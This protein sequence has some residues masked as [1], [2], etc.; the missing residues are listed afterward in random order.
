MAWSDHKFSD[1]YSAARDK[2]KNGAVADGFKDQKA[3]LLRALSDS[4]FEASA[5]TALEALR[6][7]VRNPVTGEPPGTQQ[8]SR[9]LRA[10]GHSGAS[11]GDIDQDTR[12]R[13]GALK[14]VSH[15]YMLKQRGAQK[16]WI[17]NLPTDFSD[18]PHYAASA[19]SADAVRP[20]LRSTNEKFSA[21][22]L[23]NLSD[24]MQ[25]G[26]RWC[27]KTLEV[28]DACRGAGIAKKNAMDLLKRWFAD[29]NSDDAQLTA[30]VTALTTGFKAIQAAFN[31]N[32]IVLTDFPTLRGATTGSTKKF[33]LSEAFVW[34]KAF[35]ETLD[36]IYIEDGFFGTSNTMKGKTN[37][38]RI[39]VHELSHS[40]HGTIDVEPGPR[41]SWYG[42]A[43]NAANFSS[44]KAITNAD[45]WA[46]FAADCAGVLTETE[47]AKAL[48]IK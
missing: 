45:S 35:R 10:V 34:G 21:D 30:H 42:I 17:H 3:A 47:R 15:V 32:Q 16:V 12:E 31:R 6:K 5:N 40:M 19:A 28:L 18:W 27:Q 24:A 23:K 1:Q 11:T 29:E 37:W 2:L 20:L 33:R 43:P 36:V 38:A 22:D 14:F 4:G 44:A 26:L 48:T 41:Y 39:L 25:D 9:L 46:F 13:A 7:H 8:D